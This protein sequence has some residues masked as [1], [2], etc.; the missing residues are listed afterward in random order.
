MINQGDFIGGNVALDFVNTV[1]GI[2]SGAHKEALL[3]YGDL[4]AWAAGAGVIDAEIHAALKQAADVG[5]E[6]AT[7][8]LHQAR[9]FR[10][11]L[12]SV[13]HAAAHGHAPPEADL[14][15]LNNALA[16][17]G[18]KAEIVSEDGGFAWGWV[19]DASL[20]RPLW[21]V[22]RA[23]GELLA[24]GPLHRLHECAGDTCGWLFLDISK[25]GR[26]RWCDMWGCGNRAKVR[27]HRQRH[28]SRVTRIS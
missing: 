3:A 10:E 7:R 11:A 13:V 6:A 25:G 1:S 9:K 17:A 5:Q 24:A 19:E 23:A 16:V 4:L 22:A 12:H 2:R 27:R 20:D 15:Y 18:T 14:A 28:E 21:A 8:A 26:R